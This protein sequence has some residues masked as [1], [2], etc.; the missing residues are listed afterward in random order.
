MSLYDLLLNAPRKDVLLIGGDFN[1]KIGQPADGEGK[2]IGRFSIGQWDS[3]EERLA[4]FSL[5]NNLVVSSTTFRKKRHTLHTWTLNE[6]KTRNQVDHI[7]NSRRWRS[8]ITNID[9]IPKLKSDSD[10]RPVVS[11]IQLKLKSYTKQLRVVK[12]DIANLRED[13]VS[14]AYKMKLHELFDKAEAKGNVDAMWTQMKDNIHSAAAK[15]IGSAKRKKNPWISTETL[16]MIEKRA[17]ARK[18]STKGFLRREVKKSVRKDRKAFYDG[19]AEQMTHADNTGDTR[20]VHSIAKQLSSKS[21]GLSD[22]IKDSQGQLVTDANER[23][24]TGVMHFE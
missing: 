11:T 8:S 15:N 2:N 7:V 19:L 17:R 24:E 23:I 9:N 22:N 3:N 6:Q 1:A 12:Y 21:S 14:N 20:K 18:G 16:Q 5:L 4:N 10:H 13:K